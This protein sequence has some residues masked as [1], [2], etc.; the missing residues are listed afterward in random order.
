MTRNSCVR[1]HHQRSANHDDAAEQGDDREDVKEAADVPGGQAHAEEL[2]RED[3]PQDDQDQGGA[4][5]DD[6]QPA[7]QD[8]RQPVLTLA[9]DDLLIGREQ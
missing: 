7:V 8:E 5:E 2:I 4:P 6:G 1:H 3:E 9:H